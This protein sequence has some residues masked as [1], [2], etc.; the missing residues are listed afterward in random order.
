[1]KRVYPVF[2]NIRGKRCLVFGGGEV[3]ERK[4]CGLIGEQADVVIIS[5]V[6]TDGLARLVEQEQCRWLSK[7]YDP[8]DLPG[9]FLAFAAT[10]SP[11]VQQ[12]IIRDAEALG[13]PVNVVDDPPRSTFHVPA[14]L[15]RGDLTIAVSTAGKS[16]AFAAMIRKRLAGQYGTE[17]EQFLYLM[18]KLRPFV[19]AAADTPGARKTL[20]QKLLHEDILDWIADNRWDM[21]CD[22]L[23]LVLGPGVDAVIAG[24]L[25]ADYKSLPG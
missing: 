3:A 12:R 21:V 24:G 19:I 17:Y 23:R 7:T 25:G 11:A 10:D 2:F 20:F 15:R 22:H 9:T 13:I 8:D 18:G 5:P 1:V 4:V 14:V 16:P 6:V